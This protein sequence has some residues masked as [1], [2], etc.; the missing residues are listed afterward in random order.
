MNLQVGMKSKFTHTVSVAVP[1]EYA[2]TFVDT[3]VTLV[4]VTMRR[5]ISPVVEVADPITLTPLLT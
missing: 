4:L 1:P 3:L 2:C 5:Q